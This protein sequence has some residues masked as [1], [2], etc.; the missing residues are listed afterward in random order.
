[1]VSGQRGDE[2]AYTFL[3][4]TFEAAIRI[5]ERFEQPEFIPFYTGCI[6]T[7]GCVP[8]NTF[9]VSYATAVL[10]VLRTLFGPADP[11]N[12]GRGSLL[13]FMAEDRT[14]L[15]TSLIWIDWMTQELAQDPYARAF[16]CL[17]MDLQQ[18]VCVP[19]LG[20]LQRGRHGERGDGVRPHDLLRTKNRLTQMLKPAPGSCAKH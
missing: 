19:S 4:R 5:G 2:V 7:P 14:E 1:M 18:L 16:S 17:R 10:E 12:P 15:T 11:S 8:S 13:D 20:Q 9:F 6:G 3:L